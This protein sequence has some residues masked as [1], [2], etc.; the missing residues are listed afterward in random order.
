M[1]RTLIRLLTTG[2][3]LAVPSAAHA[4][5]WVT[6]APLSPPDRVAT[7]PQVTVTP[8]GERVIAW[9]QDQIDGFTSENVSIRVAPAGGDF[10]PTQTISGSPTDLQAATAGDGTVA[11][12]WV[13]FSSRTVHVA[14]LA[15]GQTTFVEATP[16][17][18]PADETP[19]SV[20]IAWAGSDLYA[21]AVSRV[22]TGT[23]SGS[24]W[25]LRL[26]V[27][28]NALTVVPGPVAS[29]AL[30]HAD[31]V[32]GQPQVFF[33]NAV[34][35]AEPDHVVVG[36]TRESE[37]ADDQHGQTAIH[38]ALRN[39]AAFTAPFTPDSE[40]STGSF[41]PT[42]RVSVA[43][44]GSHAYVLWTRD[45][46]A[47]ISFQDLGNPVTHTI[48]SGGAFG[49]DDLRS[50]ADSS[51][52]LT[53]AWTTVPPNQRNDS[54]FSAVVAAGAISGQGS[55]ITPIG[56]DREIGDIAVASDGSSLVLPVDEPSGQASVE[57]EAALRPAGG[58][59]GPVE[60]VSGLLDDHPNAIFEHPPSA[61]IA[62]G[63]RA[64]A[65]WSAADQTG[66]PNL[67]VQLSEFDATPPGLDTIAVP[68]T[69]ITG[70]PVT[71]SA[72]AS[73]LL[74]TPTVTWT[75]GDGSRATGTSVT[76]D[77]GSAGAM[78][79]TVTARDSV[80]NQTSQTRAIAVSRPPATTPPPDATPPVISGLTASNR[81][82]RIAR[83]ATAVVATASKK[84]VKASASGTVL[85]MGLSE[86]STLVVTFTRHGH[87][88]P[89][90]TIVR[91]GSGPGATP[92][93]FSG[94]IG[95]TALAPGSYVATVIA[96]DG[97]GNRSRP[98]RIALTVV[99]R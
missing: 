14:R 93:R 28:S 60:Q 57:V 15:P 81:K 87:R 77:F 39:G 44:G 9:V 30:E 62:P 49:V 71:V 80:G 63:G 78:T 27:G 50:A 59:F 92:V 40:T 46:G 38:Y 48:A 97:S 83:G 42:M 53:A 58:T 96:I 4:A 23:Q 88:Q 6:S 86:R 37:D 91:F 31:N 70:Q 25:A 2:A 18:A 20:D 33:G 72:S 56:I 1:H 68:A 11:I 10:G 73:D 45:D 35:A 94:R 90:G 66:S 79:V 84:R 55:A 5:G 69:A 29:G 67:R 32:R 75:F 52:A 26:A 76:H 13:D 65:L 85:R 98:A 43:A 74:S 95:A 34:I 51:G 54:V 3:L 89:A 21:G 16:F 8:S 82:F 12:A 24:V 36:W 64:L 7:F 22:F 61:F 41:A 17:V 19:V 47:N 99:K